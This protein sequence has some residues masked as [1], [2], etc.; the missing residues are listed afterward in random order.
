M[1]NEINAEFLLHRL[2]PELEEQWTVRFKG[3]FYRNYTNDPISVDMDSKVVEV[4]RDGLLKLLPPTMLSDESELKDHDDAGRR[5]HKDW[6]ERY[7][8]L[9]R[10]LMMLSEAFL[11]ID[12]LHF[13]QSLKLE[14]AVS[15]VLDM[16]LRHVLKEYYG[17]DLDAITDEYTLQAAV[18]LPFVTKL[19][20][21]LP[22]VRNMLSAILDT[23]VT[24]QLSSYSHRDNNKGSLP[25]VHYH[26]IIDGLTQQEYKERT[27]RLKPLASF[28][29]EWFIPFDFFSEISVISSITQGVDNGALLNYNE[30]VL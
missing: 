19:R 13:R 20:G 9:Q 15:E 17:I 7:Q 18:L 27:E 25:K 11:P 30:Y 6:K 5:Y 23:K 1:T 29:K 16:K 12:T 28:V 26:V 22:F 8:E 4:A 2:Y 24:M 21:K 3:T 10:R 14:N